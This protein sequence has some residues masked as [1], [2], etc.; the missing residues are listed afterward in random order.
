MLIFQKEKWKDVIDEMKPLLPRHWEEV[1]VDK[2]KIRLDPDYE[3]YA[4]LCDDDVLFCFTARTE[5]G[6][7]VGYLWAF[8]QYNLHYKQSLCAFFDVYYLAP[9]YRQGF[10]GINLFAEAE[11]CLKEMGVEKMFTGTKLLRDV[12]KIFQ[13]LKWRPTE[14]SFTKYIGD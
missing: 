14:Q 3:R 9:E 8:V 6:E 13:Y 10:S 12:S 2:D 11:K 5:E 4:K 1:A 7:L